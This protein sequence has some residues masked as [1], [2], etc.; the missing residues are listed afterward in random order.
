LP[1]AR[2]D[3]VWRSGDLR[4]G[5]PV[6]T[7]G[8]NLLLADAEDTSQALSLAQR[9]LSVIKDQ[10]RRLVDDGSSASVDI[11]V[12]IFQDAP[13][14][15]SLDEHFMRCVMESGAKLV[16]SAYPCSDEDE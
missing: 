16:F 8:F 9:E 3:G 6:P 15:V 13:R 2:L 5:K 7:P 10:V 1:A 11:G 12:D 14:S 4:G